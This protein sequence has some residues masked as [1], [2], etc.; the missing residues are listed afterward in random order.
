MTLAAFLFT[1]GLLVFIHELGHF[2]VA[3]KCGV[4]VEV[5]SL[6]FGPALFSF[7]RGETRYC[8]CA[9]PL[10]GYVKMAGEEDGPES[11]DAGSFSNKSVGRRMAIVAAGPIMNF[12]LPFILLPI[13]LMAGVGMPAYTESEPVAVRS[14]GGVNAGDTI[15][16]VNGR[17][18]DK[19]GDVAA[20]LDGS[21]E[22]TAEVLRK[23]GLTD[24]VKTRSENLAPSA[25]ALRRD[26]VVGAV[27]PGSPASGAGIRPGD[28]VVSVAGVN[29]KDW[30][31]MARAMRAN[32]GREVQIIVRRGAEK[33][34]TR[35]V[36]QKGPGGAFI[37]ITMDTGETVVKRFGPLEAVKT[38]IPRAA[39]MA[40]G[41][42]TVLL[43]LL[44]SLFTGEMS[45]GQAGGMV[46]GPLLI[47]KMS[48]EVAA[49]G[50]ASL[51]MFASVIS[52][53]LAVIN[54]FPIPVLDGGHMIY[55]AIEGVRGKPLPRSA[56]EKAGRMGL[57][58]LITVMV[59][60]TYNDISK[61]W[62]DIMGLLGKLG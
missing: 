33:I 34:E 38:G 59:V 18:V 55:L 54:L 43:S 32:G 48:G 9:L 5:F 42:V 37:G 7:V 2:L 6:G 39:Q 45:L 58:L 8:V 27:A 19:W 3:R 57:A 47:A 17:K 52:V 26:A 36:P 56:I 41:V 53:N 15:L 51:L 46:A 14:S 16:S 40:A 61:L 21:G 1:I 11:N 22:S 60:A 25:L 62:D 13:A 12:A 20:I 23:S 24:T 35:A 50:I 44:A 10:G 28:R 31:S 4:R 49:Q 29:V 30:D